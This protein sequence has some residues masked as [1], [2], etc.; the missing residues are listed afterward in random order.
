MGELK[1]GSDL[2]PLHKS[3]DNL[4]ESGV[5]YSCDTR[6]FA[7]VT[8]IRHDKPRSEF[9]SLRVLLWFRD[10]RD[11]ISMSERSKGWMRRLEVQ[12]QRLGGKS[13]R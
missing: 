12:W 10:G 6:F 4:K 1:R 13:S 5:T 2:G 8:L 7:V 3:V 9:F 11:R